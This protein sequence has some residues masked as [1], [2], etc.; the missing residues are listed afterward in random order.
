MDKELIVILF[1]LIEIL[2][3]SL[4]LIQYLV[5]QN[6]PVRTTVVQLSSSVIFLLI[7]FL[8]A[9]LNK[10]NAGPISTLLGAYVGYVFGKA[11]AKGEWGESTTSL[12]K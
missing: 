6:A 4:I 8:L 5:K 11:S 3:F 9:Y 7:V 12:K 10:I 1:T 2:I